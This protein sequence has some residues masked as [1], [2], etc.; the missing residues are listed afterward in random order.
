MKIAELRSAR[1]VCVPVPDP[2][3]RLRGA[4]PRSAGPTP[5][6]RSSRRR[7]S[8]C[9]RSV[10]PLDD[11]RDRVHEQ[12]GGSVKPGHRSSPRMRGYSARARSSRVPGRAGRP[13]GSRRGP[14][15]REPSHSARRSRRRSPGKCARS[16]A[17]SADVPPVPEVRY[18]LVVRGLS[19]GFP[20]H[21]LSPAGSPTDTDRVRTTPYEAA[22]K[23]RFVCSDLT[24]NIVLSG[25]VLT[26]RVCGPYRTTPDPAS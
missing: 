1:R 2:A 22:R 14:V 19:P 3:A 18:R 11:D 13:R 26:P 5:S 12:H 15:A 6:R 17:A 24:Q 7:R 23:V 20:V 21:R 8:Y 10:S 4:G 25:K 9:L 16:R